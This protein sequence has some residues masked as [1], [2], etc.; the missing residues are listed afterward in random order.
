M[1][2]FA[3]SITNTLFFFEL[4]A[5]MGSIYSSYCVCFHLSALLFFSL[6]S[7]QSLSTWVKLSSLTSMTPK[8]VSVYFPSLLNH[9]VRASRFA[10]RSITSATA[11]LES[12]T[13]LADCT[14]TVSPSNDSVTQSLRLST[15]G[16]ME[17][18]YY[19]VN[20]FK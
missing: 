17:V 7:L 6:G 3:S 12:E 18:T 19:I 11:P 13:P 5:E 9:R 1:V 14:T 20:N 16:N 4:S 15:G 2:G 10:T 8:R